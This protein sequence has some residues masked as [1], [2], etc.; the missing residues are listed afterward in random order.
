MSASVPN[1]IRTLR[2]AGLQLQA[3]PG[4]IAAN[5]DHAT[6]WVNRQPPRVPSW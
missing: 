5:L 3:T 4:D 2:V 1:T 6:S